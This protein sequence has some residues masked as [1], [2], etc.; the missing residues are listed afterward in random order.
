MAAAAV[1]HVKR[2]CAGAQDDLLFML[3]KLPT[4]VIS[5]RTD[6]YSKAHELLTGISA[7]ASKRPRTAPAFPSTASVPPQPSAPRDTGREEPQPAPAAL[8]LRP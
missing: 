7:A 1:T 5:R 4:V 6:Q 8:L 3:Y 2:M